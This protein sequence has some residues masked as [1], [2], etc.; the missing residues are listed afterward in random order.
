MGKEIFTFIWDLFNLGF[1]VGSVYVT[2]WDIV[3]YTVLGGL[4]IKLV[5]VMLGGE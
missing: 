4:L 2:F 5:Y 1:D 3:I